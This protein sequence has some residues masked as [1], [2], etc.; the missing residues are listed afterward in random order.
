MS[1][2]CACF[3]DT[4]FLCRESPSDK[5][6]AFTH[7]SKTRIVY[8]SCL[9]Y[10]ARAD[11][12]QLSAKL[13]ESPLIRSEMIEVHGMNIAVENQNKMVNTIIVS[14]MN[15]SQKTCLRFSPN[16]TMLEKIERI[17]A[18]ETPDSRAITASAGCSASG[19]T[20]PPQACRMHAGASFA[21]VLE[22]PAAPE[23]ICGRRARA[24]PADPPLRKLSPDPQ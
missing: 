6:F 18:S 14:D 4:V 2:N 12:L 9:V 11:F 22:R 1:R 20:M 24:P 23:W 17:L 16:L 7:V 19:A 10:D 21:R 5:I 3:A 8:S 13:C 15:D